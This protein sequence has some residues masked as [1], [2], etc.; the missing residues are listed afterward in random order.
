MMTHSVPPPGCTRSSHIQ[1][2]WK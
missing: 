2:L 1:V